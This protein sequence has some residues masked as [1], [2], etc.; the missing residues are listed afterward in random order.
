MAQNLSIKR[1]MRDYINPSREKTAANRVEKMR[2][3]AAK[4]ERRRLEDLKERDAAIKAAF[5]AQGF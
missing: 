5:K 1:L 3:R 4:A 2:N